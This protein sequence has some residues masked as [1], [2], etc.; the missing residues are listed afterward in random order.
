[1]GFYIMGM[2]TIVSIK[3]VD[4]LLRAKCISDIILKVLHVVTNSVLAYC[5][6]QV[7]GRHKIVH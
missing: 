5:V 3:I 6:F 7:K 1:M 2:M 4:V